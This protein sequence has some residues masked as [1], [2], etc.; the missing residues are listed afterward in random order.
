MLDL[1]SYLRLRTGNVIFNY[2][3]C[4][5]LLQKTEGNLSRGYKFC[6]WFDIKTST[7]T[8]F[9][10]ANYNL[11]VGVL[12]PL[13]DVHDYCGL[14]YFL[15]V[16]RFCTG[17]TTSKL[18]VSAAENESLWTYS[19]NMLF[20]YERVILLMLNASSFLIS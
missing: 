3:Y 8:L 12:F 1:F 7:V 17:Y 6:I 11:P 2:R 13:F 15:F 14:H 5:N 19:M 20:L 4:N 16:L 9:T 18:S 10:E